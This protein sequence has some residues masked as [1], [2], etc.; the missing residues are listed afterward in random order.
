MPA[1][2]PNLCKRF[3]ILYMSLQEF[4]RKENWTF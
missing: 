3:G 4:M 2:I 1:K